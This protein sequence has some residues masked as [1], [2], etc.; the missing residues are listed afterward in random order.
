MAFRFVHT[1]DLHLDSP[2]RSLALR[3]PALAE[4]I[5]DASRQTLARIVA[6][7]LKE[8]VDALLIVGDLYDGALRSMKTARFL[9][10]QM[11][12]LQEAQ[13]RVFLIRG[14]HDA[15]SLLTQSV[16]WPDNVTVFPS[17]GSSVILKDPAV[18]VHGVSF[19]REHAPES[20]LP[21]YPAPVPGAFNIGLLH[22][23]LS[24]SREHD[25]YAPCSVGDLLA[26]G[27]D[28]WALGHIHARQVHH[29]QPYVVMSGMPQG[30]DIGEAGAKS[31]TLVTVDEGRCTL[32]ER[33]VS[34]AEFQQAAP[35]LGGVEG[36][37]DLE[38]VLR[39]QMQKVLAASRSEHTVLRLRLEGGSPFA[40]SLRRDRDEVASRARAIAE[41]LGALAVEKIEIDA[42]LPKQ[43]APGSTAADELGQLMREE[44]LTD[45]GFLKDAAKRL[46]DRIR[47]L[48]AVLRD[49]FGGDEQARA[50]CLE[51]LL[52]QGA[53]ELEARLRGGDETGDA[54]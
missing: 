45:P 27:Y 38:A 9:E 19:E 23:S 22:T 26:Q 11:R 17:E 39:A 3:D 42:V 6:L 13:I 18:A 28:Y 4:R 49:R 52:A 14:N 54:G 37:A 10:A 29:E 15:R 7:S 20:L 32:E 46:D 33:F 43:A 50:A 34:I 1:A 30:R 53:N 8:R 48:P 40:W 16:L 2:L 47:K 5:G 41:E 25:D 44:V 31:V 36:W 24:G 35:D 12:R 51:A 21:R